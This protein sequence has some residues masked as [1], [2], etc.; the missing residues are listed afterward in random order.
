MSKSDTEKLVA[1]LDWPTIAGELNGV[2]VAATGALSPPGNAQRCVRSIPTI[3]I[4]AA[5]SS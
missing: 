1:G 5:M 3:G 4:F 2:G